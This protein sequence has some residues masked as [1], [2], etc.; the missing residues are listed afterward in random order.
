VLPALQLLV[1]GRP[2]GLSGEV[3]ATAA[4]VSARADACWLDVPH[5]CDAAASGGTCSR[6]GFA[7]PRPAAAR[8]LG[9]LVNHAPEGAGANVVYRLVPLPCGTAA[10]SDDDDAAPMLPP[11]LLPLLPCLNAAG[12]PPSPRWVRRAC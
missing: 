6:C 4:A 11:E 10:A 9:H 5:A 12:L 2:D 8:A 1:D 7:Q 3:F